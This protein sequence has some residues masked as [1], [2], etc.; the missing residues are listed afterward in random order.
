METQRTIGQWAKETFPGGDD[1]SPRHCI[2]LLEEVIELC[3]AA[4]AVPAEILDAAYRCGWPSGFQYRTARPESPEK[5]AREMADCAIVL[6]VL[7]ERRDVDL[8]AEKDAKMAVN[9]GRKWA[10]NGDGT[11]YHI[12][13][14]TGD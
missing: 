4:G 13:P 14:S 7:A 9:R 6:D 5:V 2:R 11:G 12:K 1:L 3:L 8:Q 10:M